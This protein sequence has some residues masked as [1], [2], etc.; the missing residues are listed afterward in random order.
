MH[1]YRELPTC[2]TAPPQPGEELVIYI[3]LCM[4]GAIPIATALIGGGAFGV[5]ATVGLGMALGGVG[6]MIARRLRRALSSS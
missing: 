4:I 2:P 1:P 3:A 5:E 6:G